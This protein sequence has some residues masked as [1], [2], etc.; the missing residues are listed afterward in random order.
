M[1]RGSLMTAAE[2]SC[3]QR[4]SILVF[5]LVFAMV[6]GAAAFALVAES[7]AG[8]RLRRAEDARYTTYMNCVNGLEIARNIIQ[9]SAYDGDGHNIALWSIDSSADSTPGVPFLVDNGRVSVS[10]SYLGDSWFELRASSSDAANEIAREVLQR[11]REKDFFSRYALFIENGD[12]RIG[13]TTSYYGPVH[14]NKNV[15]F[16]DTV[17]G[18]G[19]QVYGFM[20]STVPFTFNG[21]AELE[22]AF[23][24]G[25][26]DDLGKEGWIDL[27]DPAALSEFR[28]D[29]GAYGPAGV[30]LWSTGTG[31]N[32]VE[33]RRGPGGFSVTGNV[34]TYINL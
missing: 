17:D 20:S 1:R 13:D 28:I 24:K 21:D 14:V 27:P 16:N 4:G 6:V 12:V 7:N 22:T 8:L 19:A 33:L 29:T 11:V 2:C 30:S 26:A 10:V 3:S 32:K 25:Y 34:Y 15:V 31:G 23:Y 9:T 5:I 18:V